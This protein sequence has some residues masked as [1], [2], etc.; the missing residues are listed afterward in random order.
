MY[1]TTTIYGSRTVRQYV[2]I[3]TLVFHSSRKGGDD[4]QSWV[5]ARTER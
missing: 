2:L 4:E 3:Y 1:R 5:R